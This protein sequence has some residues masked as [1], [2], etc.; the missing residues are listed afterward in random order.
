[1]PLRP[2]ASRAAIPEETCR[3][4]T[5]TLSLERVKGIEPILHPWFCAILGGTCESGAFS[6]EDAALWLLFSHI[7]SNLNPHA[8]EGLHALL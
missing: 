1:M 4:R 3:V 6:R 5:Q 8:A 2:V 7:Y